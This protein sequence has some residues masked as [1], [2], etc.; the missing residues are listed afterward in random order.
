MRTTSA[1]RRDI[2]VLSSLALL[3]ALSFTGSVWAI[4][5]PLA[6]SG[7][8]TIEFSVG[9]T[10]TGLGLAPSGVAAEFA[11][12]G[13]VPAG[14]GA[15]ETFDDIYA[16]FYTPAGAFG[17]TN[18]KQ[19]DDGGGIPGA[20]ALLPEPPASLTIRT[21]GGAPPGDIEDI[22]S[23]AIISTLP[24]VTPDPASMALTSIQPTWVQFSVDASSTGLPASPPF[25]PDVA[26]EAGGGEALGDVF[27]G[28]GAGPGTPVIP[29]S[30]L[31]A[32]PGG[33]SLISDEGAHGLSAVPASP[34]DLDALIVNDWSAALPLSI[35]T[36][37]TDGLASADMPLVFFTFNPT[38]GLPITVT[39]GA[40][41]CVPGT[42]VAGPAF[43]PLVDCPEGNLGLVP[44]DNIDALFI[45]STGMNVIFSLDPTSPTL[46]TALNSFTGVLGA[47]PSDL[48]HVTLGAPLPHGGAP[49][50]PLT[51]PEVCLLGLDIGLAP[52]DNLNALWLSAPPGYSLD[53]LVPVE[54]SVFTAN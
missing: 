50:L 49:T 33:N 32:F 3:L 51:P 35:N 31:T 41:I 24:V 45:D 26:S 38:A 27:E 19:Y 14:G 48:I 4:D 8:A 1:N 36:D 34:D 6:A 11:A 54:L 46:G 43:D 21:L 30:G 17:Y 42:G 16:Q 28:W 25:P 40:D 29:G 47:L 18:I 5:P 39:S 15:A 23:F 12:E 53:A 7:L 20:P 44:G 13:G 10:G 9:S 37:D 22:D 2:C 52:A